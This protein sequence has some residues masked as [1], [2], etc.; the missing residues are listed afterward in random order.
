MKIKSQMV[1]RIVR[2]YNWIDSKNQE[3]PNLVGKCEACGKCCDFE[4]Y[5]H[6]LFVTG[7]EML[8][9]SAKLHGKK[10][11]L[12]QKGRCP[13]N[14]EGKC[15][16]YKYRFAGC[17]IFC[18]NGDTDFQSQLSESALDIFKSICVE[19]KIPYS[20]TELETALEIFVAT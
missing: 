4:K 12:T 13:F 1:M 8:Y 5:D 2:A 19:F 18:C 16:I 9:L 3:S 15:T 17:R 10:I 7:P 20:Y 11:K 6:R 14:I